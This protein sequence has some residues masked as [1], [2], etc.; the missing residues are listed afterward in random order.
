VRPWG[1]LWSGLLFVALLLLFGLPMAALLSTSVSQTAFLETLFDPV[2]LSITKKTALQAGLSTVLAAGLGLGLGLFLARRRLT[3]RQSR[4]LRMGLGLPLAVPSLIAAMAWVEVLSVRGPLGFSGLR[5]SFSAVILA[6][7]FF[8]VPWIA[9]N[10][11]ESARLISQ[12][13]REVLQSLGGGRWVALHTL[14]WPQVKWSF[15][16][17]A[18]QTFGFCVTSFALV[19]ILGGGPPVQT[20]ET[21]IFYR[22]RFGSLDL[23]G[24]L[25]CALWEFTLVMLPWIAVT[26]ARSRERQL[27]QDDDSIPDQSPGRWGV[28]VASFLA[29]IWFLPYLYPFLGFSS[30][31]LSSVFPEAWTAVRVSVKLGLG[32]VAG[33]LGLGWLAVLASRHWPG[34]NVILGL[35]SA[36]SI[37]VLGLGFW[38]AYSRWVD[39][40]EGSLLAMVC[41][42]T[43]VFFPIVFRLLWGVFQTDRTALKET[44][45]TQGASAWQTFRVVEW[46]V[47]RAPLTRAGLLVFA[48]SLGEVAAVSLFS[49]EKLRPLP[50]LIADLTGKYRFEAAT[51]LAL[52]ILVLVIAVS[53]VDLATKQG[54]D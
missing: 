5:Y 3:T 18:G 27:P 38:L 22:I 36:S 4:S 53:A 47:L 12:R 2:V 9:W 8:N 39:P 37:L 6:H 15:F 34:W 26:W 45:M 32:A 51:S 40:F 50:M 43:V 16:S 17:A 31:A 10:V 44:A 1:R 19:L 29:W 25:A 28:G 48:A 41:L 30:E 11:Y 24:A 14:D 46:P 23:G 42:Q 33:S 35:P 54:D 7:V 49:S 13:Q 21:A 52:F 20:L